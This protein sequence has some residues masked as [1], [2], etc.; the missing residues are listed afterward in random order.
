M[1]RSI[2]P[3]GRHPPSQG[4]KLGV[5]PDVTGRVL[6][7]LPRLPCEFSSSFEA[8]APCLTLQK[9]SPL[10]LHA[11]TAPPTPS[12]SPGPRGALT[13]N[14]KD[15]GVAGRWTREPSSPGTP[16][17]AHRVPS[18]SGTPLRRAVP[19]AGAEGDGPGGGPRRGGRALRH[20][21]AP[22]EARHAAAV[23][24]LQVQPPRAPLRLGRGVHGPRVRGR[25][26]GV[27]LVRGRYRHA[28]RPET[29]PLAA[30]CRA[31]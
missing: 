22:A 27:V 13:G 20:P 14:P 5:S 9:S 30:A 16:A 31:R 24:L 11:H 12:L 21:P 19:G 28:E 7:A 25:G 2:Q 18:A 3:G 10:R 26:A 1:A 4:I 29:Q 17:L 8:S 15:R 23:R 6:P